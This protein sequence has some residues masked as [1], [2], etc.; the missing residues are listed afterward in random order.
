MSYNDPKVVEQ[1]YGILELIPES[2]DFNFDA[3]VRRLE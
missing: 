2:S 3:A 1:F